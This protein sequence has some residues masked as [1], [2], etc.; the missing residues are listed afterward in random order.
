MSMR[1]GRD[2]SESGHG[3]NWSGPSDLGSRRGGQELVVLG[4]VR[5]LAGPLADQEGR[6]LPFPSPDPAAVLN[7]WQVRG[8][9]WQVRGRPRAVAGA[10][11]V[12]QRL[13][14]LLGGEGVNV[15]GNRDLLAV[16]DVN[17]GLLD[18]LA[19][20][21]P[22]GPDELHRV[23]YAALRR[24]RLQVQGVHER[25]QHRAVGTCRTAPAAAG[26]CCRG[27]RPRPRAR[28]STALGR[29]LSLPIVAARAGAFSRSNSLRRMARSVT[30]RRSS[31]ALLSA[32]IL[33]ETVLNTLLLTSARTLATIRSSVE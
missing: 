6:V 24:C 21:V 3:P 12:A 5:A 17:G 9:T 31:L 26:S 25:K 18:P 15:D 4:D 33:Q 29:A 20:P 11:L 2:T 22:V 16:T 28:R 27:A 7:T 14:P 13:L 19:A 23:Q 8:R 32:G 30:R 10:A 1:W